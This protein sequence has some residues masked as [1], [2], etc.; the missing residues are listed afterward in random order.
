MSRRSWDGWRMTRPR[1]K[2]GYR[3][4]TASFEHRRHRRIPR[5]N[6][7]IP[8][9]AL[10]PNQPLDVTLDR[11]GQLIEKTIVPE[12]DRSVT[13]WILPD[14]MPKAAVVTITDLELVCL[15]KKQD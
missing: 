8:K 12:A 3:S 4:A 7:L 5:G 13:R 9:E 15:P 14:G 10:S 1:R 6:R 11:N 2:P